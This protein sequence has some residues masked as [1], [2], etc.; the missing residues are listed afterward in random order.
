MRSHMGHF[1]EGQ[2]F[3]W[4]IKFLL[5]IGLISTSFEITENLI[6]EN[7]GTDTFSPA[8]FYL[9]SI[10]EIIICIFVVE[11]IVRIL[12]HGFR[13][14]RGT[15]NLFDLIIVGL[16]F[17]AYEYV[18]DNDLF[19]EL[20]FL[21]ILRILTAF[22]SFQH[23]LGDI[24]NGMTRMLST[25]MLFAFTIYVFA[26]LGIFLFSDTNPD[27]FG[28][29]AYAADTVVHLIPVSTA[30]HSL[31]L[32]IE[33]HPY[34][35]LY[36]SAIMIIGLFLLLVVFFGIILSVL[37]AQKNRQEELTKHSFLLGWITGKYT[38]HH[39]SPL[40]AET[41]LL[42]HEIKTLHGEIN[43]IKQEISRRIERPETGH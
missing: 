18:G 40:T 35:T 31:A 24:C 19:R 23:V 28:S 43:G 9:E 12:S 30:W 1:F 36:C 32:L 41:K 38:D 42:M 21:W 15:K 10:N 13:Y 11:I 17:V 2:R 37:M 5:L 8:L 7:L 25:M 34:G 20:R 26:L 4:F 6:L 33:A 27:L 29:I 3:Q 14:F 39:D 16:S 22:P